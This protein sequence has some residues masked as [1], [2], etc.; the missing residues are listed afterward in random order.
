M[1]R[2]RLGKL[3][4]HQFLL[5]S[6]RGKKSGRIYRTALKPLTYDHASAFRDMRSNGGRFEPSLC[7]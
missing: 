7:D 4:G 2:L 1:Y 3:F 5:L 6:H